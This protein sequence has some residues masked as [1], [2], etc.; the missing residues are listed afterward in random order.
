MHNPP[1][2]G[3]FCHKHGNTIKPNTAEEYTCCMGYVV[4]TDGTANSYNCSV[5]CVKLIGL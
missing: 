1:V 2:E 3:N 4:K 5:M